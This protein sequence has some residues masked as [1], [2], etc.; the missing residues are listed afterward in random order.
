VVSETGRVIFEGKARPDPGALTGLLRK[1][2]ARAE[3]IGLRGRRDGELASSGRPSCSFASM[4]AQHAHAALSVRMN[5]SDQNDARGKESR[6]ARLLPDQQCRSELHVQ[7][8]AENRH[9]AAIA[10]VGRVVDELIIQRDVPDV[11]RKRVIGLDDL[12]ETGMRQLSIADHDA[13]PAVVEERL[14]AGRYVVNDAG[15]APSVI[16]ASPQLAGERGADRDGAVDISEGVG[17]DVGRGQ[18]RAQEDAPIRRDLLLQARRNAASAGVAADRRDIGGLAGE[19][20]QRNCIVV[21][22]ESG[23]G[24]PSGDHDFARL[25]QELM[26][27]LEFQQRLKLPE[28]GIDLRAVGDDR[29]IEHAGTA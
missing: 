18:S 29:G 25:S 24:E 2:V 17:F 20:R 11:D 9:R 14:M 27:T 28:L 16:R 21:I 13:E 8:R 19:L 22:A 26:A 5:K 6:A 23:A 15:D 12:F 1:H 7:A 10:I 3:R 4:H